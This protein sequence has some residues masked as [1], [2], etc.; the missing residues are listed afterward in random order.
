MEEESNQRDAD[1]RQTPL[2]SSQLL[3]KFFSQQIA[4]CKPI[5][6]SVEYPESSH[7]SEEFIKLN[8][9]LFFEVNISSNL[10]TFTV[11]SDEPHAFGD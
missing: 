8:K 5:D 1:I 11:V 6:C 9:S 3:K 4:P 7:H 10:L 2:F